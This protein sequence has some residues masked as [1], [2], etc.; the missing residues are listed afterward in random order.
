[1]THGVYLTTGAV[2][3]DGSSMSV[4]TYSGQAPIEVWSAQQ[5][6]LGLL[7]EVSWQ[8]ELRKPKCDL[9]K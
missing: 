6:F 4:E 1:M 3:G 7:S 8:R 2:W 5:L 9:Q